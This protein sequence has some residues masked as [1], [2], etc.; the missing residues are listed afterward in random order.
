MLKFTGIDLTLSLVAVQNLAYCLS[1]SEREYNLKK[2]NQ[3]QKFHFIVPEIIL[4]GIESYIM[5]SA[6]ISTAIFRFFVMCITTNNQF[7]PV[8]IF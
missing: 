7:E 5:C 6:I 2:E 3:N 4:H 8:M 1:T